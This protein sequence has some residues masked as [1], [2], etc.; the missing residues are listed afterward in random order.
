MA[1]GDVFVAISN[2]TRRRI[3]DLLKVRERPAGE[4]GAAFPTLPQPAVSRHLK[5]L[6][7]AGLVRVSRRAQRRIYALEPDRLRELDAWVARYRGFW[8]ERLDALSHHLDERS[9]GP[10]VRRPERR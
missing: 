8:T 5:V 1:A 10:T 4:V 3:L 2:P 6:R 7:L 9:G